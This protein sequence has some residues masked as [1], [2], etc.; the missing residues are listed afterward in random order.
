V[1]LAVGHY[2]GGDDDENDDGDEE[3]HQELHLVK[4]ERGA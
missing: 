3:E 2:D 1:V 4:G